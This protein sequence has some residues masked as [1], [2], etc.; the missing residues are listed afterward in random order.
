MSD[1]DIFWC[2]DCSYHATPYGAVC[3]CDSDSDDDEVTSHFTVP[4]AGDKTIL[5]RRG[6]AV[7][8][9]STF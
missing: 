1:C 6:S 8:C 4:A 9:P 2:D 3:A 7:K 5:L